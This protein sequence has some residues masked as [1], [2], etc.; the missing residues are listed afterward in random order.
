[1]Q[2]I[3]DSGSTK[4]D[5]RAIKD[6]G[7]IVEISTEGIN[8]VFITPEEIVKI[9]SQKLLPVIGPGVKNVYF[10]GAG[11]VSPQLI[12]TLSESFK[13]VLPY[14]LMGHLSSLETDNNLNLVSAFEKSSCT[15]DLG[16]KVACV[17]IQR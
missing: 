10:Y 4:V 11:V 3:A 17:D 12:A 7:S 5:W 16:I 6:D 2:L 13:K 1:M 14:L 15:V 9:L 8:P